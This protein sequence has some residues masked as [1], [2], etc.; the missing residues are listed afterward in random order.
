MTGSIEA[1]TTNRQRMTNPS[2]AARRGPGRGSFAKPVLT[3]P[4]R[5]YGLPGVRKDAGQLLSV[6]PKGR[7]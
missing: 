4:A 7:G 1:Q 6:N 2:I 3:F 5:V